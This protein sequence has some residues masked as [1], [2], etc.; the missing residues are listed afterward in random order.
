MAVLPSDIESELKRIWDSLEG[1]NKFRASLFNLIFY[2]KKTKRFDYI[3][4]IAHKVI[5]KFPSRI[6]FIVSSEDAAEEIKVDVSVISPDKGSSEVACDFI[7]IEVNSKQEEKIPFVVLPHILPDLPIYLIWA[8]NPCIE[9]SLSLALEKIADRIIFDSE[10]T[11]DLAAFSKSLLQH[12]KATNCDI[13]D[14]NW[15][16][17]ES[18]RELL[19]N[20]FYPPDRLKDLLETKTIAISYNSI[21]SASYCHTRIQSVY[22]QA[23]LAAQLQWKFKEIQGKDS[24]LRF[25]YQKKNGNEV[26]VLLHP[27]SYQQMSSGTIASIDLLTE[28]NSTYAFYRDTQFPHQI[29][30]HFCTTEQCEIPLRYM[31]AKGELGQSLVKE[32]CH[33]GTSS[34]YLKV[35][36]LLQ[37]IKGM[38]AC[39]H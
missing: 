8:E 21:E 24:S 4:D 38:N 29:I 25:I 15:A 18:W 26:D 34:H 10:S 2:T 31:F 13:A 32:I 28:Q 37:S 17:M 3:S 33:K 20:T 11:E 36:E 39:A 22:L 14:L 9:N 30:L 35:L 6:I 1:T 23:W 27:V 16:R 5:Q 19:S 12:R 7:Q